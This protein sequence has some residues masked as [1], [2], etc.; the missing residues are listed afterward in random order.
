MNNALIVFTREPIPGKTKTRLMPRYTPEQCAE[1]H[2]CFLKDIAREI[3]KTDADIYVSYTGGEPEKLRI[4]FG[5]AAA[6]MEQEGENLGDR[7]L[8]AIKS[9][10]SYGYD[11]IVLIGSDVP[12]LSAPTIQDA[13]SKLDVA[14][15]VIGPTQDG[16]YYLIGMNEVCEYAFNVE[17]YGVSTVYEDTVHSLNESGHTVIA[18]DSYQDIDDA[19]DVRGYIERMRSDKHLRNSSTG[20][21]LADNMSISIIVPTYNESSTIEAMLKQLEQYR[22]DA[23]IIIVDGSSTDDTVEKIGNSWNVISC[24]KC[25]GAQLNKG[26]KDSSGD[27]LFFLHCDC[28]LPNDA[29]GEIRRCMATGKYGCFGLKFESKNFFMWTNRVIS[30]HRAWKRGLPFGDQGIFIDRELFFR[31][32]GFPE[33]PIMEDYEFGRRLAAFGM[34]PTKTCARIVASDRRY[35]GGTTYILGKEAALWKLRRR[36]RAGE[37]VNALNNE[38]GDVR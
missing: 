19:N 34:K 23:E 29:L 15:T 10:K 1:L 28:T 35:E 25:R 8:N 17:Q 38:Y 9:V 5:D 37:D 30:N 18:T 32:G 16:G 27:V 21:Y 2:L 4:V 7:M 24:E 36:Y 6:Y 11:K 31:T 26:A 33:I 13:F 3:A 20:R 22:D 14:D 12:E